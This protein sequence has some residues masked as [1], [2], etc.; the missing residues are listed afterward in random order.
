MSQ[1]NANRLRNIVLY[2]CEKCGPENVGA[3]KLHKIAYYFDMLHFAKEGAPAIGAQYRKKKFGPTCEELPRITR[4]MESA[5]HIRTRIVDYF[6]Y[7]KKEIVPLRAAQLDDLSGEQQRLLDEVIE[8]V[9]LSNTAKTISDFSHNI[10]WE[11]ADFGETIPYESVFLIYPTEVSQDAL[12]WALA[13]A[14]SVEDSR[15]I[16]PALEY[17][18]LRDFRNRLQA[19]SA[20]S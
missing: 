18:N 19:K 12:D 8:F 11:T 2:A 15:S 3:V 4:D 14:D 9:C 13:E 10:A 6:G 17:F 7:Q 1:F 5:R 16:N 20:H